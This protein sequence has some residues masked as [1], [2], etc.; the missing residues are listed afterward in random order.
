ML[1]HSISTTSAKPETDSVKPFVA[2]RKPSGP[3]FPDQPLLEPKLEDEVARWPSSVKIAVHQEVSN[4]SEDEDVSVDDMIKHELSNIRQKA[5]T[6]KL[7]AACG[8]AA[9]LCKQHPYS[10]EALLHY[11]S[12]E[13]KCGNLEAARTVYAQAID[14]LEF[15]NDLGVEYVRALQ[16]WASLEVQAGKVQRAR[17]LYAESMTASEKGEIDSS[18]RG[19]GVYGLHGWALLEE[20]NG[21]WAKARNL[22][23]RAADLQPGNAVVHQ[24]RASLEARAHNVSGARIHFTRAVK[25]APNDV[26]CWHAWA[27]FEATRGN[28]EKMRNLFKRALE[29]DPRNLHSLQAWAYHEGRIQ[30]AESQALARKLYQDCVDINPDNVYCWQAWG[31]LEDESKNYERARFLFTRGLKANKDSVPCL[32][33]FAHMERNRGN[34][35]EARKLL[36]RAL[37]V[38]PSNAPALMELALVEETSGNPE[39]ALELYK[40]AE[41]LDKQKSLIKRRMFKSRKRELQM[42]KVAKPPRIRKSRK[43]TAADDSPRAKNSS[44]GKVESQSEDAYTV[45]TARSSDD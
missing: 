36:G 31:V 4:A 20:K 12:L 11:A 8:L 7:T 26:K 16:A 33:A 40:F 41:S 1:G 43:R 5:A 19:A 25:A 37:S 14:L 45:A 22:L 42:P 13:R 38:E 27:K 35:E 30:T 10:T 18:L 3:T 15:K 32:Q 44:V 2:T 39:A 6:G 21:N 29:V 9:Q 24:S 17:H 28:I 23:E 34:L